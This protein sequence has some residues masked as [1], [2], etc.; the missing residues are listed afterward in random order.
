M[1][2]REKREKER[3]EKCLRRRSIEFEKENEEEK[4]REGKGR[5]REGDTVDHRS[6]RSL[7]FSLSFPFRSARLACA[8][9]GFENLNRTTPID[10]EF[11]L[12]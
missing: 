10:E 4:G 12:Q 2:E 3:E 5:E 7:S 8:A 9:R 1:R 11:P 6:A